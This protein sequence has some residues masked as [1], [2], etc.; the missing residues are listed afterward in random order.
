MAHSNALDDLVDALKALPGVGVRSA[1][2]MAMHLLE[3]DRSAAKRLSQAIE[4]SLDKVRHCQRCNTFTDAPICVT[5]LDTERDVTRLCVVDTASDQ[6]VI[7]RTGTYK[8]HYFVLLG[9]VNPLQGQGL[10]DIGVRACLDRA[11]DGQVEEV[12]IATGF[13]AQGEATAHVLSTALKKR[14]IHVTRLA[15]GVPIGSELEFV[16]L[17]TIAHALL[18][19]RP[20]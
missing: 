5:C 20:R 3:R 9:A 7:E 11:C 12:I 18:D 16:D 4:A 17:G 14:G 2:R 19:R 15:R 10:D 1:Q 6:S 8:G 13:H